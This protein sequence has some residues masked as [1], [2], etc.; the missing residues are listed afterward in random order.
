MYSNPTDIIE[1]K[2]HIAVDFGT[3]RLGIA[4]AIDDEVMVNSKW[5]SKKYGAVVKPKTIILLNQDGEFE[6]FGM[7]AKFALS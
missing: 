6:A 4:Y 3:D 2:L 7:D 1:F 5:K